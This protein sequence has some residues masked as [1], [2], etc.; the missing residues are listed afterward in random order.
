MK[1]PLILLP[2][3]LTWWFCSAAATGAPQILE[4][5]P[6]VSPNAKKSANVQWDDA[7][8]IGRIRMMVY[9]SSDRLKSAVELPQMKPA[10]ANLNWIND[11]WVACESFV[12]E[13]GAAFFYMDVERE[14]GYVIEI[15]APEEKGDWLISFTTN[16]AISS[17]S[18][19]TLSKGHSAIFPILMRDLPDQGL[20]YLTPD[21]AVLL[22]DAVDAYTQWRAKQ[23]FKEIKFLSPLA[24]EA[25]LGRLIVADLDG[26]AELLYFPQGTT[27]TREMLAVT[28]RK[29]LPDSAQ[30]IIYGIDPP[31]LK[32]EWLGASGEFHII[33]SRDEGNTSTTELVNGRFEGAKDSVYAGPGI[34][35]LL[36][37]ATESK[38]KSSTPDEKK[39]KITDTKAKSKSS[40][41]KSSSKSTSK[42]S[43]KSSSKK[44]PS[45][46]D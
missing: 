10:P 40:S 43:S 32:V 6:V 25:S 29:P 26:K 8:F 17:D 2:L 31:N 39:V 44:K 24:E 37:P 19:H 33:T 23:G 34:N 20:P 18:I 30:K 22:S 16:D 15:L 45:K 3:V 11:T 42:S 13:Q 36:K 14:K 27:T 5:T 28:Q 1:K 4:S 7:G 21:F 46:S 12:A 41:S 38:S 35:D 9:D